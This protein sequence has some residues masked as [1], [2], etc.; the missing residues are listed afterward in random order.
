MRPRASR[1]A[2]RIAPIASITV[3]SDHRPMPSEA[4]TS[5]KLWAV[6]AATPAGSV[7]ALAGSVVVSTRSSTS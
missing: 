6:T 4:G 7:R 1:R 3:V 5:E 2:S